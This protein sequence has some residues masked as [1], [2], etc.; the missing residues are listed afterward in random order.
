MGKG[1]VFLS[2]IIPPHMMESI[3]DCHINPVLVKRGEE[4]ANELI[5]MA[6]C[7]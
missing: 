6:A 7:N 1:T 5:K 3:T 4:L 2:H